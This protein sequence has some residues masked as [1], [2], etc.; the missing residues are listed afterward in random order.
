MEYFPIRVPIIIETEWFLLL[1]PLLVPG[2]PLQLNLLVHLPPAEPL[3]LLHNLLLS[4]SH[5]HLLGLLHPF[6]HQ[7]HLLPHRLCKIVQFLPSLSAKIII[8]FTESKANLRMLNMISIQRS[9]SCVS[10]S[11]HP[12]IVI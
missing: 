5:S 12:F 6:Y 1:S 9:V 10:C 8:S 2:N 11:T 7:V 4:Q 3:L